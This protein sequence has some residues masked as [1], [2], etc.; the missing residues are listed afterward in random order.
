MQDQ[1]N[2]RSHPAALQAISAR[3]AVDAVL[4]SDYNTSMRLRDQV[5]MSVIESVRPANPSGW[6]LTVGGR[7]LVL[8]EREALVWLAAVNAY[9][10]MEEREQS[11]PDDSPYWKW[12][13]IGGG[14]GD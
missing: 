9:H 5:D 12:A 6:V 1:L 10:I 8:S 13:D 14:D 7:N 11:V 4:A 3:T 2:F